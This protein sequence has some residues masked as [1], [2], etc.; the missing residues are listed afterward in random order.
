M[1]YHILA[2]CISVG[3]EGVTSKRKI[4]LTL[5]RRNARSRSEKQSG[6][7][8]PRPGDYDIIPAPDA[9]RIIIA[10]TFIIKFTSNYKYMQDYVSQKLPPAISE[11][12]LQV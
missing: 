7:K 2:V 11:T 3:L 1:C 10:C 12:G 6:R 5:L 4:N 8:A 9:V